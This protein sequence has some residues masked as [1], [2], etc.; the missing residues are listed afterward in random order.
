MTIGTDVDQMDASVAGIQKSEDGVARAEE[1]VGLTL[2]SKRRGKG[3]LIGCNRPSDGDRRN[4][5]RKKYNMN[6]ADERL[7]KAK[8]ILDDAK[9]QLAT[10]GA[11]KGMDATTA[12]L[13]SA[14]PESA[15]PEAQR[16][17]TESHAAENEAAGQ[18]A[19][20]T[21]GLMESSKRTSVGDEPDFARP[22]KRQ[23]QVIGGG[24]SLVQCSCSAQKRKALCI[25]IRR[26]LPKHRLTSNS[27]V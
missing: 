23:K 17:A 10:G 25:V 8:K 27:L 19:V 12:A 9:K 2:D 16:L 13:P 22:A 15:K 7:E 11:K 3:P 14:K 5:N 24:I 18:G 6:G 1:K 21:E 20:L 26:H 4:Y